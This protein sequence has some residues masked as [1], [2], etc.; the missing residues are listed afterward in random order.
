M[1]HFVMP[2]LHGGRTLVGTARRAVRGGFGETA[3]PVV[4][5]I[6]EGLLHFACSETSFTLFIVISEFCTESVQNSLFDG[7][8]GGCPMVAAAGRLLY[9]T[10]A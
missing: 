8:R 3:L 1:L 2:Q 4:P 7:S 5:H 9:D 10:I 6:T